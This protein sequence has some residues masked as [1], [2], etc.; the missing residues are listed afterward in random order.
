MGTGQPQVVMKATEEGHL[1]ARN[2]AP[3]LCYLDGGFSPEAADIPGLES[4][5]LTIAISVT[6][7][8]VF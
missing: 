3:H 5:T 8:G 6:L 1:G 2:T 7:K 4:E